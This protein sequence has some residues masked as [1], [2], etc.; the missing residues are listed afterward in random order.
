M[1]DQSSSRPVR[2]RSFEYPDWEPQYEAAV[3]ELDPAK[4]LE[5]IK[6]AH[7]HIAE[8]LKTLTFGEQH[9]AERK[10]MFY[11]SQFLSLLREEAIQKLPNG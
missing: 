1:S 10:A 5:Y 8:R 9:A 7:E 3:L 2:K 4:R 11:S 6:V